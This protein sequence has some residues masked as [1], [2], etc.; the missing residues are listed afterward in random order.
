MKAAIFVT[1]NNCRLGIQATA[2]TVALL[3]WAVPAHRVGATVPPAPVPVASDEIGPNGSQSNGTPTQEIVESWALTP[4]GSADPDHPGNRPELT[5]S[6]SPGTVLEDAVTLY[7][8]GNTTLTFRVYATDAF[9]NDEGKF[10][11]LTGDKVPTDVGRWVSIVQEL[12]TVPSG[13]QVTIPITIS[14]PVDAR[15]GDHAGAVVASSESQ[16]TGPQGQVVTLDRRTG[17]RLYV[18]VSGPIVREFAVSN[19]ETTYH[20]ALSPLGGSATVAYRIENRGNVRIGG[21]A[22]GSITGPFGMGKRSVKLPDIGELLPGAVVDVSF[23]IA[24]VPA[25]MLDFTTVRVQPTGSGEDGAA[26]ASSGDDL[27]FAPPISVLMGSLAALF[28]VLAK[29]AHRRHRGAGSAAATYAGAGR[30]IDTE[31]QVQLT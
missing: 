26:E 4:A 10:D 9:N 28:A 29:R 19:V 15:P 6:S 17:T 5:Y 30:P 1:Y 18:R 12:I 8:Y 25:L 20:H 16:G 11:L 27:T 7:N 23:E 14:I 22:S 13:K 21:A 2:L 24:D 3:A 31:P